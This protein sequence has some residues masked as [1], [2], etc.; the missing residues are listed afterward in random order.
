MQQTQETDDDF[1]IA[2]PRPHREHRLPRLSWIRVL[3]P[4]VSGKA[5][6]GLYVA[7]LLAFLAVVVIV[8][9]W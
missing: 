5:M 9:K 3:R 8:G 1:A 2:A 7:T 6:I 4:G